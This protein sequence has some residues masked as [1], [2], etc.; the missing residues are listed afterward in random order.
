MKKIALVLAAMMILLC[1]FGCGEK[2]PD[3]ETA[4]FDTVTVLNNLGYDI[5]ELYISPS[6]AE[7]WQENILESSS[8]PDGYTVD[9]A[10][11]EGENPRY[12]DLL[13]IGKD[14]AE[15]VWKSFD[16]KTISTIELLTEE[17]G[18]INAYI[19]ER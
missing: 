18:S 9:I 6:Y 15:F 4:V 11:P 10:F 3:Y 13:V 2:K 14:S 5:S 8:L 16:F 19:S 17:D 12:W 1:L 7:D